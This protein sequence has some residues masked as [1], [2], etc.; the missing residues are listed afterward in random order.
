MLSYEHY[1]GEAR[2]ILLLLIISSRPSKQP[3][4]VR[5]FLRYI[6]SIDVYNNDVGKKS[7]INLCSKKA[8]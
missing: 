4:M 8:L 6:S 1:L 3:F 2:T 5:T 7:A